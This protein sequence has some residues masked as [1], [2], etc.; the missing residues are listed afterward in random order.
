MSCFPAEL[1]SIIATAHISPMAISTDV[2]QNVTISVA[3]VAIVIVESECHR[4]N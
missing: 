1:L 4:K 3:M 2:L